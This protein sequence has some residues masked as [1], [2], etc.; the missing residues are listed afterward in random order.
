MGPPVHTDITKH[1]LLTVV[2]LVV[3]VL[4]VMVLVVVVFVLV[5][6]LNAFLELFLILLELFHLRLPVPL[7]PRHRP[8]KRPVLRT[9]KP[10]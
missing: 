10:R 3:K 8:R 6:L 4:V 1:N 2:V 9:T 7:E 5:G